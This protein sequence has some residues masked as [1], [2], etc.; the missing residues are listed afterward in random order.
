MVIVERLPLF[1]AAVSRDAATRDAIWS[2]CS[3]GSSEGPQWPTQVTTGS[4]A[5]NASTA[6]VC[7]PY[8]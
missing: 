4:P 1:K 6:L 2:V 5:H 3:L 7:A 8:T